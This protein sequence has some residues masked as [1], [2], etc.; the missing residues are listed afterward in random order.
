MLQISTVL[1]YALAAIDRCAVRPE[2]IA[3]IGG[4]DRSPL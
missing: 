2:D 4:H 1:D 3:P